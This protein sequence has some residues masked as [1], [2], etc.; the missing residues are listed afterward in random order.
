MMRVAANKTVAKEIVY[1]AI[2]TISEYDRLCNLCDRLISSKA[3]L[4]G[5]FTLQLFILDNGG[6]LLMESRIR[7][8]LEHPDI[9]VETPSNNLGVAGSWNYFIKRLGRCIISN[10]DVEFGCE[11]VLEFL[12]E[13]RKYPATIIFEVA[14]ILNGFSTFFV[15]KPDEWLQLG[16]F[17]ESFFPAYYEDDDA[18]Y[19][20]KLLGSPTRRVNL[21]K[22]CHE[23]SS[24]LRNSTKENRKILEECTEANRIYYC[25]KWGG[26]PGR[27][28]YK[29]PFGHLEEASKQSAGMIEGLQTSFLPKLNP[30]SFYARFIEAKY[31]I[32]NYASQIPLRISSFQ[33]STKKKRDVSK[34]KEQIKKLIDEKRLDQ[35]LIGAQ[36]IIDIDP[37]DHEAFAMVAKILGL[38]RRYEEMLPL[39]QQLL[40]IKPNYA[41]AYNYLG[42]MYKETGYLEES[43]QSFEEA[44]RLDPAYA[45]ALNNLGILM[46]DQYDY[47]S[48]IALYRRS[49]MANPNL[50]NAY[51]NLGLALSE[52]G[53]ISHARASL[54]KACR[55]DPSDINAQLSLATL[56]HKTGHL[57][58]ALTIYEGI[59]C[60][61]PDS[62]DAY[63][64]LGAAYQEF[65]DMQQAQT[66]Y[67]LAIQCN[68]ENYSAH[69]NLAMLELLQGDYLNGLQRY[70]FRFMSSN[71]G[72]LHGEVALPRWCGQDLSPQQTLLVI[73]E[74]GLGDTLH[75]MRYLQIL[76]EKGI[77][78]RFAAQEKLHGLIQAS[79]IDT[80]PLAPDQDL[81][82][83][84]NY[85]I[86]LMSIPGLLGVEPEKPLLNSQYIYVPDMLIKKWRNKLDSEKRPIIGLNWQGNP[87]HENT[88]TKGRS[89]PLESFACISQ[90]QNC[91]LLSLQKGFGSEQLGKCSFRDKFVHCQDQIDEIWDFVETAAILLNCDL[92]ITTDTSLAHLSGGLNHP[93]WLLLQKFP[94]WRWGMSGTDSFWYP[95]MRL[96]RQKTNGEWPEVI[97]E[98]CEQIN[99]LYG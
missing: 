82:S 45:Q 40:K 26:L 91:T 30:N 29:V 49:I 15:N 35:A 50:S 9:V 96:F 90:Q 81:Q 6:R 55:V 22:W 71:G 44:I 57:D 27:E 58:Q 17:D 85:W 99:N 94:E 1:V 21:K 54:E 87:Q 80:N 73:A 95:S 47:Q 65:G 2:P 75:F 48:A 52:V 18:R 38:Q 97:D 79:Q 7:K 39:L 72:I 32:K 93:T 66:S 69:A 77:A 63:N 78:T 84:A 70:E 25:Q 62:S 28:I 86:P 31:F 67:E 98:V 53:L 74:Q 11:E 59:L 36:D 8:L 46:H 34:E 16:G 51:V 20:L 3:C 89:I 88:T 24:T 19:R 68:S 43:K 56:L 5:K 33:T 92:V 83:G 10:D 37:M 42:L 14:D 41:P 64:N 76:K 23:S 13:S 12:V 60:T 4:D 61:Q